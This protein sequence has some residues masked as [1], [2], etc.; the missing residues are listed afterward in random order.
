[1]TATER[2]PVLPLREL[3]LFP[4]ATA[5]LR[6]GR[7]AS[8]EALAAASASETRRLALVSQVDRRV[9]DP[10]AADVFTIGV[11]A[12]IVGVL[13]ADSAEGAREVELVV[14][15]RLRLA[16][17]DRDPSGYFATVERWSRGRFLDARSRRPAFDHQQAQRGE[18]SG[19]PTLC[20]GGVG[21]GESF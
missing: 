8:L 7:Q 17:F 16:E 21:L 12:Q 3:V 14:E 6:V 9:D 11:Q 10:V 18:S 13:D 1:M 5:T 20:N 2:M 4:G 19:E 15:R